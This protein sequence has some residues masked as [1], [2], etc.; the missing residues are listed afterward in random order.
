M[1]VH[2]VSRAALRHRTH[3][4]RIPE[5]LRKRHER[6]ND[7]RARP[8]SHALDTAAARVDVARYRARVL[9]GRNDL[10]LHYR[11]EQHRIRF[12]SRVL[13]RHRTGDLESHL[14]RVNFVVAA[15]VKGRLDVNHLVARQ[16]T[17]FHRFLDTFPDA[18]YVL[19][20]DDAADDRIDKLVPGPGFGRFELDFGVPVLTASAR[21][22]NKLPDS[23]R[24]FAYCL[25]ISDL[26]SS[27]VRIDAKLPLQAIDDDLEVKLTHSADDDLARFLIGCYFETGVFGRQTLETDAQLLLILPGLGF[28]CLGDDGRG[29]FKSLENDRAGLL[30]DCVAG[31][32]LLEASH[33]DDLAC[34]RL[35]N[36]FAFVRVHAHNAAHALFCTLG[37]IQCVRASFQSARINANE[38]KLTDVLVPHDLEYEA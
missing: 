34:G 16:H 27:D 6:G 31:G 3:I 18:L 15:V 8:R 23:F 1:E 7:L 9:F 20:R 12:L 26:R 19:A 21:L 30:T 11:L 5:H 22:T 4:S 28:D 14:R 29:E 36:I 25:S 2:R 37:R 35:L 10:D 13:E 17:A 33:R 24:G 38:R 32:D